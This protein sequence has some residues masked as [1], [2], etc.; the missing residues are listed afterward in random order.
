MPARESDLR[1]A[2]ARRS[3]TK[4]RKPKFLSLVRIENSTTT[5]EMGGGRQLRRRQTGGR[6]RPSQLNLFPLHPEMV[7]GLVADHDTKDD[8]D[9]MNVNLLFNGDDT[10][11]TTL[12]GILDGDDAMDPAVA[13]SEEGS[14]GSRA[15]SVRGLR[16]STGHYSREDHR[17][18]SSLLVRAAM[19]SGRGS[20]DEDDE[21]E[22]WVSYNEVVER[23]P[24]TAD[25]EPEEVSSCT[26][27][28]ANSK[29]FCWGPWQL[30]R[31][32]ERSSQGLLL[33]LKLDYD[34]I[35]NSWS[36]KG[37]LFIDD[38]GGP[39]PLH[40]H[41]D[42]ETIPEINSEHLDP[43]SAINKGQSDG[44]CNAAAV[45]TVPD[46]NSSTSEEMEDK[47]RQR[48]ASVLRYREK[49]QNRLFAKR[50]RYEVRKLNAQK[51]P[52]VKGRF[53]RRGRNDDD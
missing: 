4:T 19:K 5:P 42:A 51:R 34:E 10:S 35:L 47:F 1:S 3:R 36:D 16:D 48:V 52:R 25:Q 53:V 12:S 20:R 2:A 18:R 15:D 31:E 41:E 21:E 44:W 37:S 33:L 50:V 27:A 38:H 7:D 6:Q 28:A 14:V 30:A 26:A 40:H 23:K 13:C 22:K 49:R 9:N 32:A 46:H 8:D 24:P 45:W 29:D 39:P 11:A 17:R 43:D